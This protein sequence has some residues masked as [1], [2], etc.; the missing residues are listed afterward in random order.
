M[1][2]YYNMQQGR[3]KPYLP[4]AVFKQDDHSHSRITILYEI[5]KGFVIRLLHVMSINGKD[6]IPCKIITVLYMK[7]WSI[8]KH[9]YG[10][11]FQIFVNILHP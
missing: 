1:Q 10:I 5:D 3:Y 9:L 2:Q 6:H 7:R 11:N 8:A 4:D